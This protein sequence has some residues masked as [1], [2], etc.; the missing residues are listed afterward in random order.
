[1]QSTR[2]EGGEGRNWR[3]RKKNLEKVPKSCRNE[4]ENM[5]RF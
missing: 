4:L 1:L 3:S 2:R 5:N